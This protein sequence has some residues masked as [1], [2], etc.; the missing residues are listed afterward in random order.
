MEQQQQQNKEQQQEEEQSTK[1]EARKGRNSSSYGMPPL[2]QTSTAL[3]NE[4]V[5][6]TPLGIESLYHY[7]AS[8][9]QCGLQRLY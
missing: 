5:K 8:S 9:W 3:V 2:S 4:G 1:E 6:V 7:A